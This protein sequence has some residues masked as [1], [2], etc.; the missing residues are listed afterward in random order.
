M[1]HRVGQILKLHQ[2][3][4]SLQYFPSLCGADSN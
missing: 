1:R 3:D 2:I 4:E